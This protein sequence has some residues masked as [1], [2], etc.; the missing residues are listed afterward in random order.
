MTCEGRD[1]DR[2]VVAPP[3]ASGVAHLGGAG[4]A[5]PWPPGTAEAGVGPQSGIGGSRSSKNE[6]AMIR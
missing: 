2:G 5:I 1:P 6:I 4:N 3:G